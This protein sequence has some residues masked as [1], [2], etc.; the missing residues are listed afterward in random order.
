MDYISKCDPSLLE[1]IAPPKTEIIR[2]NSDSQ[3]FL[4]DYLIASKRMVLRQLNRPSKRPEP[5]LVSDKPWEGLAL[6]YGNVIEEPDEVRLYYKSGGGLLLARSH[7][8]IHFTKVPVE[9]AVKPGTNIVMQDAFD[10]QGMYKDPTEPDPNRRYKLLASKGRHP[11]WMGGLSS[12]FSPDGIRW[13]WA[14]QHVVPHFGDRCSAWYDPLRRK[15]VAW[16]RDLRLG[17]IKENYALGRELDLD[18][19]AYMWGHYVRMICHAESDDFDHWTRPWLAVAPDRHDHPRTQ[20]YGGTAFW[21]KSMYI[22]YI[23]MYYVHHE[24]LDTQ[25]ICSRD[26]KFWERCCERDI[27]LRNGE[28]DAFDSYWTVPTFNPPVQRDGRLLIHYNGRPDPHSFTP[29]K[30]GCA[31]AFG[32]AE[33][34]EDGFVSLDAS[35]AEGRVETKALRPPAGARQID[36]NAYPFHAGRQYDPMRITVEIL[37]ESGELLSAWTIQPSNDNRQ[38]W[39]TILPDHAL[40]ET[41]RLRFRL[42]NARLYSFRFPAT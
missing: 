18:G 17:G 30:P 35:G 40:S 26:G 28:H 2:I 5:V 10:C 1:P 7:D 27:F 33:L 23:E 8:G 42:R 14:K 11:E 29:V 39:Y 31:A 19:I 4:D 21:Y 32:L 41:L 22:G 3:L 13:T 12:A 34:R 25:L 36:V 9:N 15:H 6:V 24:R 38:I 20:I 16:C 37:T